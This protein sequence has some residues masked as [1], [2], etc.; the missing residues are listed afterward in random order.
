ME[1]LKKLLRFRA[2]LED[3]A[4]MVHLERDARCPA[5]DKKIDQCR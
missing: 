1:D 5:H 3:D 2:N 4:M